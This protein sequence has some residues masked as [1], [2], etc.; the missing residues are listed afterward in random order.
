MLDAAQVL[1]QR[2]ATRLAPGA[3]RRRG[4]RLGCALQGQQLGLEGGCG[5]AGLPLSFG[6][7]QI[8]LL[9]EIQ[10]SYELN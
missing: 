7:R 6:L 4:A 3:C 2:L 9:C 10:F 8:R 1:W 5:L